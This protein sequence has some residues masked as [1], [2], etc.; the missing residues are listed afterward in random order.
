MGIWAIARKELKTYF[1]SPLAHVML[2]ATLLLLGYLYLT[3]AA[4]YMVNAPQWSA[5]NVPVNPTRVLL[6]PV[7]KNLAFLLLF[8]A[9][10]LSM[11]LFASERAS[12]TLDFLMSFPVDEISLVLGK[13]LSSLVVYLVVLISL[14][15]MPLYTSLGGVVD[16]GL[17]LSCNL[18]LLLQGGLFLALGLLGSALSRSQMTAS[19]MSFG[20]LFMLWVVGFMA[21][22]LGDISFWGRVLTQASLY[23]H[24]DPFFDGVVSLRST[25]YFLSLTAMALYLCVLVLRLRRWS[26]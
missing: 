21:Q 15:S 16:W 4:F 26:W 18:G 23:Y 10:L 25:V 8:L 6:Q 7:Y 24:A 1:L 20:L 19:V 5:Y 13:Y 14:L 11:R 12:G 3:S 2:G 9:P 17:V 22:A